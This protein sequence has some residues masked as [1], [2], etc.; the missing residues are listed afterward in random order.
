M[1]NAHRPENLSKEIIAQNA[2]PKNKPVGRR[3][4]STSWRQ[5]YQSSTNSNLLKDFLAQLL[6]HYGRYLYPKSIIIIDTASWHYLEEDRANV[7]RY[8][9]CIRVPNI[10]LA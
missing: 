9:S 1:Q 10:V 2:Y 5:V 7:P 4:Y 3:S 8:R 6:Y